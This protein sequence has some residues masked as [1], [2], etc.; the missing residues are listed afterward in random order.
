MVKDLLSKYN[1]WWEEDY[2][3]PGIAR[4]FHLNY[5][6]D[7]LENR[8]MVLVYGLRRCGKTTLMKQLA[9]RKMNDVDSDHIFYVSLDHP[10]FEEL[11]ISDIIDTYRSMFR[12]G[13]K[14]KCYILLD[15]VQVLKDF[16]KELKAI[17]DLEENLFIV[18]SG[19]NSLLIKHRSGALTGRH[20]RMNLTPIGFKEF[21]KFKGVTI[22]PSESYMVDGYLDEYIETGG[23]PKYVLSRDPQY[24]NDLVEDIIYKD[25]V[26][27]YN[28][29]NPRLL[30]DLF[31]LLCQRAGQRMTAT[32]LGRVL[33]I[34]HDTVS[35]YISY[36][37]ETFLVAL[38]ERQGTPNERMYS[39]KK[40]YIADQGILSIFAST[41]PTGSMVEN[42][43]YLE[44][45]RKEGDI[46]YLQGDEGEVDFLRDGVAYEIK[47]KDSLD[48]TDLDNIKNLG[49]KEIKERVM[50]TKNREDL[51][52]IK[53][54][55]L[56][57][58]VMD[59][60]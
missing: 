57:D 42:L 21:L 43:A 59:G 41:I 55:R 17:F 54:M 34:S 8:R 35:N 30:M 60:G 19:S 2:K 48:E 27:R 44:L 13:R 6:E 4:E 15:E 3:L 37:Q 29:R 28:V 58:L 45:S 31:F 14:E 9:F 33:K 18:C 24:I 51:G 20:G 38:V 32:K 10:G 47:Y 52:D 5:L 46:T 1:P 11:S 25:I 7:L 49:S 56:L 26:P 36:L 12:L 53:S 23:I 22:K 50:I 16:E 39:P 40:V